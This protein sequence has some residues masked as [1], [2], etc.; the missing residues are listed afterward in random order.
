MLRD[1]IG[2]ATPDPEVQRRQAA[3]VLTGFLPRDTPMNGIADE[4]FEKAKMNFLLKG[5][6]NGKVDI[7]TAY[8]NPKA[9]DAALDAKM[10]DPSFRDM[11]IASLRADK[12]LTKSEVTGMQWLLKEGGGKLP[13]STQPN[14]L[15]DGGMGQETRNLISSNSTR[16]NPAE[17]ASF[18]STYLQDVPNDRIKGY[19][20][21]KEK[22][23]ESFGRAA[24]GSGANLEKYVGKEMDGPKQQASLACTPSPKV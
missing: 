10:R 15:L 8:M 24:T 17:A 4:K 14:G 21:N 2:M 18:A 1:R 6:H 7:N 5:D 11:T 16:V 13:K 12:D 20:A 19:D 9:I 3:L 22:L 23:G